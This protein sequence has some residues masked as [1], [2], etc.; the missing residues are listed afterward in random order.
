MSANGENIMIMKMMSAN[1]ENMSNHYQVMAP[2]AV[3]THE[4]GV[5]NGVK[6]AHNQK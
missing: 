6:Y 1:G 2:M 4:N 5:S 3:P